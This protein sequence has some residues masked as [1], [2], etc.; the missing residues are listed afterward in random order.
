MKIIVL[1]TGCPNCKKLEEFA[2]KAID[3]LKL[4]AKVEKITQIEKIMGYGVMSLPALVV[5]GEVKCYGRI[6]NIEE[7]KKWLK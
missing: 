7:I 6:P 2:Q 1:G 4:K 5:D 3:E